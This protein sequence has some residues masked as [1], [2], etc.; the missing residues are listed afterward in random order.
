MVYTDFRPTPLQHYVFPAHGDGLYLVVDEKNTFKEDTF[1]RALAA[2]KEGAD[3]SAARKQQLKGKK[4]VKQG[5]PEEDSDIFKLICLIMD[6]QYD[7]VRASHPAILPCIV[8]S[9]TSPEATDQCQMNALTHM[10]RHL[11]H[12]WLWSKASLLGA[13]GHCL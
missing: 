5:M 7:P 11:G 9:K 10:T 12:R 13:L 2:L 4:G 3:Q 1:Q 6:Q 8:C